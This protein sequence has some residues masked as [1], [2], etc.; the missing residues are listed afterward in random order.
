VGVTQYRGPGWG[1]DL[2]I[3]GRVGHCKKL[4]RPHFGHPVKFVCST[5]YSER[6][7]WGAFG[8]EPLGSGTWLVPWKHTIR[9]AAMPNLVV[10][11]QTIGHE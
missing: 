4:P 10:Q 1:S 5:S 9:W 7:C 3:W 11:G 8:S 2:R 6:M